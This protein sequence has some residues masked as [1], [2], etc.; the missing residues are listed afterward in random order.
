MN[1]S[2]TNFLSGEGVTALIIG[3]RINPANIAI[4]P[5]LIGDCIIAGNAGRINMFAVIKT[6]AKIKHVQ[7]AAVETFLE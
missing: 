3:T 1:A 7:Q 5:A 6:L 2:S 4:A